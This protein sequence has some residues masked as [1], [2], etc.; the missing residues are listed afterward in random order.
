MQIRLAQSNDIPGLIALLRQVGQVHR[1]IRPDIFRDR[2]QKYDETA[3]LQ[4]LTDE[5]RPI[6]V[7]DDQ[8]F[9]AGYCFCIL[10]SYQNDGAMQDRAELYI[11]D[12]CVDESLRGQGVGKALYEHVLRFAKE[13]SCYNLTLNV[14]SCNPGAMAFYERLGMRP[15][16][17]GMEQ[18]L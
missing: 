7:A 11:D 17:V 16:K 18:L 6:F 5:T 12:L 4:L 10:R 15:Y 3:L 13:T 14:W 1:D 9:V 8:G 2:C